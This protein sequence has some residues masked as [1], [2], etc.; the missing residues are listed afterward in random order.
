MPYLTW[1]DMHDG[2]NP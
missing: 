2:L 1:R